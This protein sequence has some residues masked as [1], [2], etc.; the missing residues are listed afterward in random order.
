MTVQEDMLM[1]PREKLG[2]YS[3][4]T[5]YQVLSELDHRERGQPVQVMKHRRNSRMKY[6]RWIRHARWK[7][8]CG[9]L[10]PR[11][12]Q[13]R[14]ICR[15]GRSWIIRYVLMFQVRRECHTCSLGMWNYP[16]YLGPI[17]WWSSKWFST[18]CIF[19]GPGKSNHGNWNY[20]QWWRGWFGSEGTSSDVM[21]RASQLG[22]CSKLL[23]LCSQNSRKSKL[24]RS[25]VW[26]VTGSWTR[27]SRS[28]I[29]SG[30]CWVG[31]QRKLQCPHPWKWWRV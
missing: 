6:G 3:V 22:K 11:H 26:R 30:Q 5:G 20:L 23:Q 10:V 17:F 12:S 24:W 2:R 31:F 4:K 19:F 16:L 8:S 21:N 28:E 14:K 1:W 29:A 25:N 7:P 27:R 9:M 13:Q 18:S 15:R